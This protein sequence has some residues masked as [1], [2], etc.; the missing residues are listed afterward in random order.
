MINK[1]SQRK[2]CCYQNF[3]KLRECWRASFTLVELLVVI[4]IVGL[5]AGLSVPA[6]SSGLE[7]GKE[8]KKLAKLKQIYTMNQSYIAD[9]DGRTCPM[10]D[11]DGQHWMVLLSPY[12]G[13]SPQKNAYTNTTIFRDEMWKGYK[14]N[15]FFKT[16]FG[17]NATLW[18]PDAGNNGRWN[19]GDNGG[20]IMKIIALTMPS[21]RIFAGDSLSYFLSMNNADNTDTT[22]Q[23][24]GTKGMFI[25]FDGR[26]MKLTSD[27]ASWGIGDPE[28][29]KSNMP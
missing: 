11:G 25:F 4:S 24:K 15:Q 27:Q 5:L 29:L 3:V 9:N 10:Q 14:K 22:R 26:A 6:I 28:K 19:D 8:T 17:L 7:K 20:K 13:I 23:D 1:P 16:G 12:A 2:N 18:A 21:Y